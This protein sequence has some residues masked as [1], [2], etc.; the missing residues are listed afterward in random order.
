M[1][2]RKAKISI[3]L[4]NCATCWQPPLT[5]QQECFLPL[6]IPSNSMFCVP[7][8]KPDCGAKATLPV[9]RWW[10]QLVMVGLPV[11]GGIAP[12]MFVQAPAPIEVRD[13][14]HLYCTDKDCQNARK[15]PCRLAGLECIDACSCID[16]KNHNTS[17]QEGSADIQLLDT[18]DDV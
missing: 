18:G 6:R 9:R 1:P 17:E 12:T 15:C 2:R 16:C 7:S 11:M 4:M 14:T 3:H 5:K 10:N 13:L 8:I